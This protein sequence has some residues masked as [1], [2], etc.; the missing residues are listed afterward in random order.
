MPEKHDAA[1]IVKMLMQLIHRDSFFECDLL[2]NPNL[3]KDA[4]VIGTVFASIDYIAV[5]YADQ[6]GNIYRVCDD[7]GS[8]PEKIDIEI[9]MDRWNR[10]EEAILHD[11]LLHYS[12]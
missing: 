11:N 1:K 7:P 9:I 12:R 3:P 8:V 2:K 4:R 10:L 6:D 5:Y